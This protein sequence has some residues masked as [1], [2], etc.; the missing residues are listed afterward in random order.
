ME[1]YNCYVGLALQISKFLHDKFPDIDHDIGLKIVDIV[2]ENGWQMPP[3]DSTVVDA[4]EFYAKWGL[5][6]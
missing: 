6:V 4:L 3:N 5:G 2:K 1:K